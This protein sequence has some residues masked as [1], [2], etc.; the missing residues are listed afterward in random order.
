M[1]ATQLSATPPPARGRFF[2]WLPLLVWVVGAVLFGI[3]FGIGLILFYN[4]PDG[5]NLMWAPLW[6]A[7]I[8]SV[9][10]LLIGIVAVVL[11]IISLRRST[12]PRWPAVL[13]LVFAVITP[14]IGV[15]LV[16]R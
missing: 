8:G 5:L 10:W 14:L 7:V 12:Q 16:A 1:T 6:S 11:A 3:S 2:S 13:V 4:E 9:I 15:S